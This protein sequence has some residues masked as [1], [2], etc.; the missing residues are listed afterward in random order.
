MIKADTGIMQKMQ[1]VLPNYQKLGRSKEGFS[2][3]F[4]GNM[5]FSPTYFRILA[6]RTDTLY[7]LFVLSHS[8]YGTLL[9]LPQETNAKVFGFS[10]RRW[11]QFVSV[12][13]SR[14]YSCHFND[15]CPIQIIAMLEALKCQHH[16]KR[17]VI[18]SWSS[19]GFHQKSPPSFPQSPL[20]PRTPG[21][22]SST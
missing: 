21:K 16:K 13:V 6:S 18:Q 2:T 8:V 3:C 4:R 15:T 22:H 19:L 5:D 11:I 12:T 7:I 14:S 9:W 20:T 17:R 1:K 10:Q